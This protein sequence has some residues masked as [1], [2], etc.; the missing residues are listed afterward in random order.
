[1]VRSDVTNSFDAEQATAGGGAVNVTV[2][3]GTNSLHGWASEDHSDQDLK[4]TPGRRIAR[5]LSQY[6]F[7]QYGATIGGP[8]EKDKDFFYLLALGRNA[9]CRGSADSDVRFPP[10]P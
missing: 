7:N 3:S 5:F 6:I 9:L 8:I 2:K 1:M 4:P 10:P